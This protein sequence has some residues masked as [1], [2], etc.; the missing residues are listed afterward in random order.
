MNY[1]EIEELKIDEVIWIIFIFLSILN[2]IGD[3]CKKEYCLNKNNINNDEIAKNIFTF[4]IFISS[5]VYIY[6]SYK[7]YQR[8][9]FSYQNK[10]N[11]TI[12]KK[13]FLASILVVIASIIYLSCQLEETKPNNPSIL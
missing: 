8:L 12:T 3:E 4:T 9:K 10:K 13:R 1:N 2:I 5:V 6:I 7:K 11:I